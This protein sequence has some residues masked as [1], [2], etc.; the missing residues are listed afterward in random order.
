MVGGTGVLEVV[1]VIVKKRHRTENSDERAV[2]VPS[3]EGSGPGGGKRNKGSS[4]A[5]VG[6]LWKTVHHRDFRPARSKTLLLL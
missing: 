1:V 6:P 3:C 4:M 5:P 2:P